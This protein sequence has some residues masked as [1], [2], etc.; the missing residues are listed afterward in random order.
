MSNNKN[1]KPRTKSGLRE[2]FELLVETAVFVFFVLTFVVQSFGIPTP[3]MEPTLLVGDFVL[4][5]K[6]IAAGGSSAFERA[7]LPK[8]NLRR[9]DMVVFKAPSENLGQDYVKRIVALE[10][11][12]VEIRG[13]EVRIDGRPLAEP[14]K[15]HL[16]GAL[17]LENDDFG[18]RTVPRGHLFVMGDNRDN[19]ADSRAWGFLPRECVKGVPWIVYFSYRA[20]ADAHLKTGLGDRLKRLVSFLPKARWGRLLCVVR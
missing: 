19:S 11:E 4:V 15:V 20:E 12:E 3:S 5:N 7:V 6:M 16:Y 10:G 13:K 17:R 9:G 18:P 1:G 8:R 2:T 14:Y